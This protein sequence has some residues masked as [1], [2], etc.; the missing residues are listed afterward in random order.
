MFAAVGLGIADDRERAGHKQAAE[1]TITLFADTAEPVLAPARMLLRHQANP[2]GEV[3]ARSES[4]WVSDIRH[5]SGCQQWTDT[6]NVV[7]PPARFIRPVPG[8]DHPIEFQ[9]LLLEAEQLT[10][11]CANACTHEIMVDAERAGSNL[12]CVP[13]RRTRTGPTRGAR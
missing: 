8:H 13:L 5:Q 3:T 4:P 10:T 9:N 7:K 12:Q 6:G 1:I 2:G 11:Q